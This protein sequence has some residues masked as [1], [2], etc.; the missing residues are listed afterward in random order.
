MTNFHTIALDDLAHVTGGSSE[1]EI[2]AG[3]FSAKYKHETDPA[4]PPDSDPY[5]RCVKQSYDQ[6]PLYDQ[7]FRPNR[8]AR[9]VERMCGQYR[10]G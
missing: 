2:S 4:A 3:P 9:L 1:G 7:W 6:S 5:L 10:H 8:E